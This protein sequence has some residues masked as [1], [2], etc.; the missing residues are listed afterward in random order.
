MAV[1]TRAGREECRESLTAT[2]PS[3]RCATS[4]QLPPVGPLRLLLTHRVPVSS[5][6]DMPLRTLVI[7]RILQF[8]DD[9]VDE[10]RSSLRLVS[11][12]AQPF[13]SEQVPVN[14]GLLVEVEGTGE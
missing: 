2:W 6:A 4:T 9:L 14:F 11:H 10:L 7:L 5:T 13:H 8:V 12:D 1:N 3:A